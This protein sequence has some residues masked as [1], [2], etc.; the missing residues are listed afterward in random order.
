MNKPTK[1]LQAYLESF[2]ENFSAGI[3]GITRA[4]RSYADAVREHS[5]K[6]R[7][8]F[9]EAYPAVSDATWEKLRLIGNGDVHPAVML[10]TDRIGARL[11]RLPMQEQKKLLD[12]KYRL[13][14]VSR[15]T[16][17]VESV[18]LSDLKPRHEHVLFDGDKL[19]TV[20]EQRKFVKS[21]TAT[22]KTIPGPPYR[23]EGAMLVVVRACRLGANEIKAIL[24]KMEG[25]KC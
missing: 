3:E 21:L 17:E 8:A 22:A 6:A 25:G 5:D 9:H 2:R 18:P 11:A 15:T 24:A 14:C 10:C 4:A 1:T 16:G 19:R 12:G 20:N 23:I 13:K 7:K